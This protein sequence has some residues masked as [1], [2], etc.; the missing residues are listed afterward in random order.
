VE[1]EKVTQ[2]HEAAAAA[3]KSGW[4]KRSQYPE[5]KQK[6]GK[7]KYSIRR[8]DESPPIRRREMQMHT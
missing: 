1:R 5:I 8:K 3:D 6:G 7:R 4:E 2:R